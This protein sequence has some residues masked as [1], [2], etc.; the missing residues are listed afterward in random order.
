LTKEPEKL[1]PKQARAIECLLTQPTIKAAAL[2]CGL[3]DRTLLNYLDMPHFQEA[4]RAAQQQALDS[5]VRL[6][7][8]ASAEAVEVLR[9]AMHDDTATAGARV[10]AVEVWLSQMYRLRELLD[11]EARIAALEARGGDTP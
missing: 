11:I 6:L 2:A 8:G 4:L 10:R 7:T 5:T 1:T 9:A 3:T